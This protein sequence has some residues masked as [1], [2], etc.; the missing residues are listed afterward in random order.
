MIYLYR[1]NTPQTPPKVL[2]TS[3]SKSEYL[4]RKSTRQSVIPK[5]PSRSEV[6]ETPLTEEQGP[7]MAVSSQVEPEV[8]PLVN[9]DAGSQQDSALAKYIQRFRYGQPQSRE[10][11]Q[12]IASVRPE[13]PPFWWTSAPSLSP[14]STTGTRHEDVLDV[15]Q[16]ERSQSILSDFSLSELDDLEILQLQE[17]ASRLLRTDEDRSVYDDSPPVSSEGLG[18]TDFPVPS[19]DDPLHRLSAASLLKTTRSDGAPTMPSGVIPARPEDDI[20]FQWRL[21]RKM[22]RA[23]QRDPSFDAVTHGWQ[24]SSLHHGRAYKEKQPEPRSRLLQVD[25][26]D[27]I[28]TLVSSSFQPD[29]AAH[30][31]SHMH[32]L[33]DI[34]PCPVRSAVNQQAEPPAQ[35]RPCPRTTPEEA[36]NL[37]EEPKHVPAGL[38]TQSKPVATLPGQQNK[39]D[40]RSK[41]AASASRRSHTKQKRPARCSTAAEHAE[42]QSATN[43]QPAHHRLPKKAMSSTVLQQKERRQDSPGDS[44]AGGNPPSPIHSALGQQVVSEVLFPTPAPVSAGQSESAPSAPRGAITPSYDAQKSVEVISQLL[45]EAE[46]SD[47]REFEDDP[48]LQ[49]LRRQRRCLKEQISAVALLLEEFPDGQRSCV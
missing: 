35:T 47:E 32:L 27:P 46:D 23:G 8:H 30:V 16:H 3:S 44:R 45:Q 29:S 33:C 10:E 17:R 22:E 15:D 38:L 39:T 7:W 43:I 4:S 49:E 48:L 36:L 5:H 19:F 11:R 40:K 41:D 13:K 34:L 14:V 9:T 37:T 42:L 1:K 12:Q 21:R 26:V 20:L 6:G 31:P 24:R 2:K 28:R 18:C 25:S